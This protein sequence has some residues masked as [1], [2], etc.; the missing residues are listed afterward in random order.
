MHAG[1]DAGDNDSKVKV[2]KEQLKADP[3][4]AK[5]LMYFPWETDNKVCVWMNP[6][7]DVIPKSVTNSTMVTY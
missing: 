2:K 1:T 3:E 6:Q 4:V 5:L 7:K